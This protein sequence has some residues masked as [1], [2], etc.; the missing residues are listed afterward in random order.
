M[1]LSG[2]ETVQKTLTIRWLHFIQLSKFLID[3]T[4][5]NKTFDDSVLLLF[6]QALLVSNIKIENPGEFIGRINKV[7]EKSL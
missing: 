7:L 2:S 3:D 6:D 4:N 1:E 5:K